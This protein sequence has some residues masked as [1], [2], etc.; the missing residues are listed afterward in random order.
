VFKVLLIQAN[1]PMDTMI[2]P[3]LS[4]MSAY[5]KQHGIDVKLF[6]TTFYKWRNLTGDD[7]RETTLQ[8]R[9][10]KVTF[11]DLGIDFKKTDMTD[12]Y[13]KMVEEY[14]PNLIGLSAVSLTYKMGL[15]LISASFDFH[16]PTI[17]GGVHA[18]VCPDEV[19]KE[20]CVDIVCIGE[21]EQALLELCQ[22]MDKEDDYSD[23]RNL[24]VKKDGKIIKNPPRPPIDINILPFQDWELF[25]KKRKWK[26]MGNEINITACVELNRGCPFSCTYCTNEFF[27]KLYKR[28]NYRERK[29]EKFIEEVKYLKNKHN[30]KYLYIAAESFLVTKKER[31]LKFIRLYGKIKIPFWMETRP[32]SVTDEKI[33][34]LKDVGLES[35]NIGI[36]SGNEEYR[37][38]MLNRKMTNQQIVNAVQIV[39]KYGVRIGTNNIIGFPDETRENIFETILL[40]READPDSI[41][42]HPFNPYFGTE[43]YNYCLK[44]GYIKEGQHGKDY[45]QDYI[46][47]Q[48]SISQ[49]ELYGLYRTFAMYTKFPISRWNEVKK[50]ETDDVVFKKLS[51]EYE[52][53]Y[54][55]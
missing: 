44:K 26:P 42:I 19:V 8:V 22:R 27:H 7:M 46:L 24:W 14:K 49:K 20:K 50:A 34:L 31:F 18:T 28:T 10:K 25:D 39:K 29:I 32:E 5:L 1:S 23:I 38:K 13:L 43:L 35:M 4:V 41:M 17:I 37:Y 47:E 52:K 48:P 11:K 15:S 16:I 6:D 55:P 45:R 30:I 3:N 9:K 33:K 21:G 2:P 53:R 12:D 54:L 51:K 40:N 36:E